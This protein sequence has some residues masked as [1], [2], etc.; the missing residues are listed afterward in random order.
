MLPSKMA[1]NMLK[2]KIDLNLVLFSFGF[3]S[4]L[5]SGVIMAVIFII[6]GNDWNPRGLTTHF[7]MKIQHEIANL[8]R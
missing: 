1:N 2:L 6:F 4:M 8:V 3:K 5:I 7:N